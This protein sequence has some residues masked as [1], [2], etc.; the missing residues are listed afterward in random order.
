MD[1]PESS[2]RC[3]PVMQ[4]GGLTSSSQSFVNRFVDIVVDS[5]AALPVIFLREQYV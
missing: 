5:V 2:I 4:S 3:S 1:A